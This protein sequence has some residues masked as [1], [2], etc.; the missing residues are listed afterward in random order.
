[1]NDIAEGVGTV[2][3]GA[4][5]GGAVEHEG[6]KACKAGDEKGSANCSNCGASVS[7][8]Y[9]SACGQKAH[10]HRTLRAIG[11]DLMHGVLH[12][13][14][15]LFKTLPLLAFKPGKL[16]R[17]YIE[18][19]RAKFV[20]PMAMFLFSVFA[21]FAVFQMIGISVPSDL[22]DS[23][24]LDAA[25]EEIRAQGQKEAQELRAKIE[26]MPQGDP[27]RLE[28]EQQL[29]LLDGFLQSDEQETRTD[30]STDGEIA[31][32]RAEFDLRDLET[33]INL[34]GN[35]AFD[36]GILKKWRDNPGLMLY[37][38]QAN[39]Y[40]FSWLL[41]PLSLPTMILL[42]LWRRGVHVYD[43]AVFV[44][45]SLG[46][47]SLLFIALSLLA[48]AGLGLGIVFGLLAIVAPLHIYKHLKYTYQLSRFSTLWRFFGLIFSIL[49]ILIG[50]LQALLLLGAF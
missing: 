12:L 7:G 14:G 26:A 47:M 6:G 43:H 27:E 1:M 42:F 28:A 44:T 29:A 34:T 50:F 13:D 46:F 31:T 48:T 39:G 5:L 22:Q 33:S 37:K 9:C 40:K 30:S 21:M 45:Y 18:G 15:K 16:T 36:Q 41:I 4:L 17:R 49:F 8:A 32:T 19:E 3:E 20:S 38:M 24:N 35:K 25:S 10:V 23:I 2:L 11:H